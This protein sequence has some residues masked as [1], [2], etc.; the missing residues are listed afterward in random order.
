METITLVLIFQVILIVLFSLDMT[1]DIHFAILK[2]RLLAEKVE[3]MKE[4]N[5]RLE[6]L[7]Y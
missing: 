3:L 6:N 4:E 2:N 7:G 1:I 5:K